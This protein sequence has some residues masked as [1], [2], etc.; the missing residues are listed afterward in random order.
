MQSWEELEEEEEEILEE[1]YYFSL[2]RRIS[3]FKMKKIIKEGR[4]GNFTREGRQR[5]RK[6]NEW[7]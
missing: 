6:G 4:R 7:R 2:K 5:R 3:F 1:D